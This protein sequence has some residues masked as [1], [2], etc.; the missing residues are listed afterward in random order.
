MSRFRVLHGTESFPQCRQEILTWYRYFHYPD[1]LE[2]VN[3]TIPYWQVNQGIAVKTG[4]DVTMDQFKNASV[5]IGVQRSC[6]ADQWMQK[7]VAEG[8]LFGEEKYNQLVK[9]RQDQTVRLL[10]DVHGCP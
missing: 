5:V 6:S 3:F 8:G 2:K 7:D 4:S 10:P 9:G 1:S